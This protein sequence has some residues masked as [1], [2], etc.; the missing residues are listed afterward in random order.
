MGRAGLREWLAG[1]FSSDLL[2]ELETTKEKNGQGY[3]AW[4]LL[5]SQSFGL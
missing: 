2:E 4:P 1:K 3:E 5:K